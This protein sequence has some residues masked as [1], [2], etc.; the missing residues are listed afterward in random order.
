[1]DIDLSGYFTPFHVT[2]LKTRFDPKESVLTFINADA[3]CTLPYFNGFVASDTE[4][5]GMPIE[6]AA[7][8]HTLPAMIRSPCWTMHG[9]PPIL[10]TT[11]GPMRGPRRW[12]R[13]N[14]IHGDCTTIIGFRVVVPVEREL[15]VVPRL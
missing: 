8:R 9:S 3:C 7:S 6:P 11:A 14:P 10:R 13:R 5:E 1:M 2:C 12:R 4:V 15:L